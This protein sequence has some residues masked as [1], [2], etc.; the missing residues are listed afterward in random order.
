MSGD[1]LVPKQTHQSAALE[2]ENRTMTDDVGEVLASLRKHLRKVAE[3]GSTDEERRRT[4]DSVAAIA[5]ALSEE[6]ELGDPHPAKM[7]A[8]TDSIIARLNEDLEVR[9]VL[10]LGPGPKLQ[11]L[12]LQN[13]SQWS[14]QAA[15]NKGHAPLTLLFIYN[16]GMILC[17]PSPETPAPVPSAR[18][19][20]RN[21]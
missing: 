2:K 6:S 15:L 7:G 12:V 9:P 4:D 21:K 8:W 20:F 19:P 10:L 5:S 18:I 17:T 1:R 11:T 13:N 16:S 14:A 3:A